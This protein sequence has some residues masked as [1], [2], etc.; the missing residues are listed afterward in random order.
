MKKI[1]VT[2]PLPEK[3]MEYLNKH[4]DVELNKKNPITKNELINLL[5]DKD[6]ALTTLSEKIDKEVFDSC[7]NLKIVAN[8][9]TG[10]NNIDIAYA[11]EKKIPITNSPYVLTETTAD[12]SFGLLL[13]TSRRIIEGDKIMRNNEFQGWEPLYLLG[14]DVY[15]KTLGIFGLGRIG[16]AVAKRAALGFGMKILYNDV[17]KYET[18]EKEF[19]AEY[20]EK[21]DLLKE[22]DFIILHVPLNKNTKHLISDKE[23]DL[24][25]KTSCLINVSRGAVVNEQAL[26]K[27]LKENKIFAAGLDV[28]E[29]E[30]FVSEELIKLNN[31][32]LIPHIGSASVDT[33]IAMAKLAAD[34]LIDFFEGKKPKNLLN[35]EAFD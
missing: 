33:R 4:F 2:K 25:K 26:I 5:Q 30:P 7:P 27:A 32:V 10:Y 9:A 24:M 19:N 18:F 21:N 1:L 29:K 31:V 35:K 16:K 12:L 13:A 11:S 28:F 3:G 14:Q 8:Y 17:E 6:G 22:S 34:N 15:N 23:F 20:R